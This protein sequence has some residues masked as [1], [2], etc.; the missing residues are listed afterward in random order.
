MMSL[1]VYVIRLVAMLYQLLIP[2]I[3]QINMALTDETLINRECAL[4]SPILLITGLVAREYS[5]IQYATVQ[6][7]TI[8][9]V[10]YS[11]I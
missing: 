6:Y 11:T 4:M 3:H 7:S 8:I 10:Q 5:T 2:I 9:S 1:G